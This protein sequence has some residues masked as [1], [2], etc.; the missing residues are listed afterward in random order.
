MR[1]RK[2]KRDWSNYD[3]NVITR[4]KLMFPPLLRFRTLVN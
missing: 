2:Y 1:K 4:Y 3:K